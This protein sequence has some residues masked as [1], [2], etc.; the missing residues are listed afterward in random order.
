MGFRPVLYKKIKLRSLVVLISAVLFFSM[1][2]EDMLGV[3]S[4][5]SALALFIADNF[6]IGKILGSDIA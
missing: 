3:I 5:I 4:L 2:H 6:I 1:K